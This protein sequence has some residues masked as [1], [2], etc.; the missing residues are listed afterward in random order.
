MVI[1]YS[2]SGV[3]GIPWSRFRV[4]VVAHC[5]VMV[6]CVCRVLVC[7]WDDVRSS[8]VQL[9]LYFIHGLISETSHG[10]GLG[11]QVLLSQEEQLW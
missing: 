5:I 11:L 7:C 10:L 3:R 4:R 6:F 8:I 1:L 2:L 9:W